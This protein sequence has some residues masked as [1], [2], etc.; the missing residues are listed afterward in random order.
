MT[1]SLVLEDARAAIEKLDYVQLDF[2]PIDELNGL[3]PVK[4]VEVEA[5]KYQVI[6]LA[7]S[8][9]R[10]PELGNAIADAA[11]D[12]LDGATACTFSD[13]LLVITSQTGKTPTLKPSSV[14]FAKDVSGIEPVGTVKLT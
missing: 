2:N 11:T 8:Y 13:G 6:E 9:D 3:V 7:G 14:L 12:V 5:G 1:V 4:L 10:T